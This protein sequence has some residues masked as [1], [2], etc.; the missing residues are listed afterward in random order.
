MDRE[1]APVKANIFV[2]DGSRN[3][4]IRR[5][6]KEVVQKAKANNL[7]HCRYLFTMYVAAEVRKKIIIDP[8]PFLDINSCLTLSTNST[9]EYIKHEDVLIESEANTSESSIPLVQKKVW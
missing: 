9:K 5:N 6:Q 4:S 8:L 1:T 7:C 3:C 2:V